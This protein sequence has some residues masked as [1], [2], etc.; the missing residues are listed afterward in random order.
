MKPKFQLLPF[1]AVALFTPAL[2][3]GTTTSTFSFQ[4]G[5]L[6]KDG[7]AY[8]SGASYSGVVDGRITDNTATT[9]LSTTA[10]ATIGNQ[11]RAGS[12]NGQ[13]H[14]GLFSYDLTELNDFITANTSSSSSVSVTSV[15]FKLISAGG[16]NATS[17]I[18][19]Y[20]TDPFTS[21]D[22][23]WSN[24]TTGTPWTVPFQNIASTAQYGYTGGASALTANL[25][26]TSPNTGVTTGNAL[27]WTSSTNFIDAVSY[28]LGQ[29]DKKLYLA[30]NVA[31]TAYTGGS[32][33]RVNVNFSPAATVDDRPELLITL[34][35]NTYS[36]WTGA[37]STSWATAGN[38]TT[39]P[40]AGDNVRFN[41][42]STANLSTVLNQNVNL[43]GIAL[44]TP[45]GPVSIGGGNTLTIGAGGLDLS[46]AAQN[47]TITAPLVLG[48]AQTWN[49]AGSHTL[50]ISGAVSGS[51]NITVAGAGKVS[52]GAANI[53]P[54]GAS[55]GNL[56]VSGN[57][58]LNGF[59]QSVNALTGAGT[60]DNTAVGAATLTIGNNDATGTFTGILKDTGGALAVVKTGTGA[61]TLSGANDFSGGFT[62][63]GS[64]D[65]T[66]NNSLA[67][68]TGPVVSNAG[69]L[70]G[71]AT[72]TFTNTLALN[73]ST[74]R[75]GGGGS[76][77]IT[78]NGPVT[79]TG[80]SGIQADANTGGVTLGSTLNIAGAAFTS[81]ANA[82]TNKIIGN[83]SGLGGSLA[84]T[85]GTLQ[86]SGAGNT[87]GGTTTIGTS[88]LLRL[89]ATGTLP[90]SGNVVINGGGLTIQNT[91]GW[92]HNGTITGDGVGSITFNTGTNATLAGTISGVNAITANT[93][94][95]DATI[96]GN[97]SGSIAITVTGGSSLTLS[98]N[99][100]AMSGT[101]ALNGATAGT[102]LN[103]DSATALGTGTLTVSGGTGK[104]DNTSG[105]ALT[106][107][108]N[109]A[110]TWDSN[111]TFVG[112]D[113]LNLGTGAVT[114]G[115]T[116][117]LNVTNTLTVGGNIGESAA[118]F[119]ITKSGWGTLV[120]T[121]DSTYSG[122]TWIAQ[123]SLSID[124]IKD[125]GVP[126]ALGAPSSGHIT[127][128][129]S[130]DYCNLIY[131]GSGDTTN[132]TVKL[133]NDNAANT[134][135]GSI[136]NNGT[137]P[138]IFTA[139]NFNPTIA[140]ITASRTLWL[141]GTYTDGDN[142]IQGVIQDHDTTGAVGVGKAND[143]STWVLS[144]A[145]SYTGGTT[146]QGGTLK[147]GATGSIAGSASV[148]IS[149]G[150][151]LDT[152]AQATHTM[153]SGQQ[154][155]FGID[156]TGVG[157]SGKIA[158]AGLNI[159]SANVTFSGTPDDPVYVLA[160]YTSLTGTQ[161][162]TVTGL[163]SGY[164]LDYAYPGNKIALVQSA[165]SGYA[166]WKAANFTSGDLDADH[167]G[168]GVSNGIEYF[169][170]GNT[171]STGFTS[172]PG[173][174]NN[175]VTWVKA[176]SGYAGTYGSGFVVETS[177]TLAAGSWVTA[178]EGAGPDKV[179][180]TGNNVK[181]TFPTGGKK[182]ARLKVT[183][184]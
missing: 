95:T 18:R 63:N 130:N 35:V 7:S 60:V 56:A 13:Q 76:K 147:L 126:S 21:S 58:D 31:I 146:V 17:G 47:L 71:T 32:D 181:Y 141:A 142:V 183:G 105:S 2:Q 120:L 53:L 132:R 79:A 114:M 24:Y 40:L 62:N 72:S 6:K 8:G 82:N 33:Q 20:R 73:N 25:G 107:S 158:A 4:Q 173:V 50:G 46:A 78:W 70:Y 55:A 156:P 111:I 5:D 184:P 100:S 170:F 180:V 112:T 1:F 138:L 68:G 103:I 57:L 29:A 89:D 177:S 152:S 106:L 101:I 26:G 168:D 43:N 36:D 119:G 179:V 77:T 12:P 37:I 87:Y 38:W 75:I 127:L 143:A 162:G 88:C 135:V 52:L 139:A 121:G 96:S 9:A 163:P 64:G 133:G 19:L 45:T 90:P 172:L 136:R 159:A 27:T 15:S 169:L 116:R 30:A 65:V 129:N 54:N 174:I 117:T 166:D 66:P 149:A 113:A 104:I 81:F 97:I 140:G 83:I 92:T 99:N 153:L 3:A 165:V 80:T 91:A 42:S 151:T 122:A 128:G 167:D 74:L 115:G 59:S 49:V 137:G 39:A 108:T 155:T 123:W 10:T 85:S 176:T 145:N 157:S 69:K 61:L 11:Y 67:F 118:G 102:Q 84:V 164:T 28:A 160:T 182:F 48:A 150:A 171:S 22:C 93:T 124:S 16:Q 175:S 98:G 34:D 125:Y 14:V 51:G 134:G 154:V 94:G 148:S 131:T 110:Q 178:A 109:N 41:N 161:F 23:T 86:L 144:G 44:T